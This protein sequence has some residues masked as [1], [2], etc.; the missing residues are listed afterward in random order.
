MLIKL[1]NTKNTLPQAGKILR[2][3]SGY[4]VFNQPYATTSEELNPEEIKFP[5][6]TMMPAT[7]SDFIITF[8][9]KIRGV[10]AKYV[11]ISF[12]IP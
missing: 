6:T 9:K 11:Y 10:L 12:L 4:S 1:L 2:T 8:Y 7:N 3:L 5:N